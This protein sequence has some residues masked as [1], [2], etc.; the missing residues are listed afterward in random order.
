MGLKHS[1][2][3]CL[4][5][6]LLSSSLAAA[7]SDVTVKLNINDTSSMV[8]VPGEGD[9]PAS[10]ASGTWEKPDHFYIASYV[11]GVVYGLVFAYQSPVHIAASP[12]LGGHM[13]EMRSAGRNSRILLAFTRGSWDVLED[14][15]PLI[16][17]GT[18]FSRMY[19]SFG[20]GLG[21]DNEVKML[22]DYREMDVDEDLILGP[23]KHS[24]TVE[25]L[26]E[27]DGKELIRISRG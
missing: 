24:L 19:P 18:F 13:L 22:L 5:L 17:W 25:Y 27:R 8:H 11:G 20:Y 15:M 14:R 4:V 26:G 23:G 2:A 9:M 3:A 16:G 7:S 1:L 10:Q 12:I 21:K 6:S